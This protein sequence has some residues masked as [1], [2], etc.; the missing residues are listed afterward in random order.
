[1]ATH[2][3]MEKYQL[4]GKASDISRTC[5]SH[6]KPI[7]RHILQEL[8]NPVKVDAGRQAYRESKDSALKR[9]QTVTIQYMPTSEVTTSMPYFHYT[10]RCNALLRA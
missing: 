3:A 7:Y 5:F 8:K 4:I 2:V 6:E 1:M 9:E 10:A